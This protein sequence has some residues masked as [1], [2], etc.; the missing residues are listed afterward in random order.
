[1]KE[2]DV[3]KSFMQKISN[4]RFISVDDFM[5]RKDEIRDG[6]KILDKDTKELYKWYFYH[7]LCWLSQKQFHL[8]DLMWLY[9]IGESVDKDLAY[10]YCLFCKR[11]SKINYNK[12]N[13]TKTK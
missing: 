2:N 5:K 6:L 4:I 8:K 7:Q 11:R 12:V 1:M 10:Q 13:L 9:T 3:I